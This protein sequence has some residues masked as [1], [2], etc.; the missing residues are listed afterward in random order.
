MLVLALRILDYI[1]PRYKALLKWLR[2]AG[3]LSFAFM[4]LSALFF[5][6]D[7][8][9][10]LV[11]EDQIT[12]VVA[13]IGM[14]SGLT[15]AIA[16]MFHRWKIEVMAIWPM[17]LALALYCATVFGAVLLRDE[18]NRLAG[19]YGFLALLCFL[20]VRVL[21]LT[22]LSFLARKSISLAEKRDRGERQ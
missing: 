12:R 20:F 17:A 9:T 19:A 5:L 11:T 13:W 22:I 18:G 6:P 4:G 21:E 10:E 8:P 16:T 2:V 3:Y 15:A 14:V 7:S 1:P